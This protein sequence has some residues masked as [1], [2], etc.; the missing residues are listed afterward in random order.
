MIEGSDPEGKHLPIKLDTTSNGEFVP[1]P[2]SALARAANALAHTQATHLA[3]RLGLTRRQFLKSPQGA[4]AT[5]LAMNKVFAGFGKL[6]GYFKLLRQ[7]ALDPAL[8]EAT[9]GGDEFIFDIHGH[10]VN[11]QGTWRR[12]N[13][14]WNYLLRFFPQARCGQGA[15]A[16]LSAECFIREIFLDSDTDMAVLSAVPA[17]PEDN[18]LSTEEAAATRTLVETMAS[19]HRLL[20]HGLVLPTLAGS[21]EL[22]ERQKEEHQIAAWKTYTQ[23]GPKGKGYWLDD[24]DYGLPFIE[25]ARALGINT[26][27]VHKGIPL[28]LLEY[29]YSTCRDI[30]VV[31]RHYPEMNFIVYHSGWEPGHME[32]PYNPGKPVGVDSLIKSLQDN[33]IAPNSNVY[34]DLGSTWRALMQ[35]PD[36]AAHLLGKLLA[37]VGEDNV[38][39]GTDSIWYGSPQDQIQSFRAF[40]IS[41]QYREQY[42][43]PEITPTLRAKVFGLN[44]AKPYRLSPQE[45]RKRATSDFLGRVKESYRQNPDPS[46]NTY[47]PR[48]RQEFQRL[49]QLTGGRP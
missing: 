14:R 29:K 46:F 49:Y 19:D 31:A 47:G 13:N 2:L 41:E 32:G 10:H 18:P 42:G 12:W 11:P 1:R 43:Y 37:Y 5:L 16:C 39:W 27:C 35:D 4:A 45:I 3:K 25:K 33:Q 22:M 8:A 24:P 26:L 34:A 15:F 7:S 30:G 9:L 23:W 38:L 40:Q 21:L 36:Q 48:T 28:F 44:A 20:I 6:G 17:A